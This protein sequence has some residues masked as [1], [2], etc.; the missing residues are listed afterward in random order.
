MSG[1]ISSYFYN[2]KTGFI[3]ADKLYKKLLLDGHNVKLKD[4]K[5]Y[6]EKQYTN[7]INKP[8]K[9]PK[10]FNTIY[11][12]QNRFNYQMDI[13]VYDR[14]TF[15]NY[16]YIL[17]VIDV[18][19]RY[20]SARAMTNRTMPNIIKYTKQIFEEM[21]APKNL[22]LDNEFNKSEFNKLMTQLN[23]YTHYSDPGEINKNAIVER[24][25][26]T[27][28]G[29]IQKWR[30]ATNRYDWNKVL[31]DIVYNYNH[32]KHSTIKA[33]PADVWQRKDINKQKIIKKPAIFKVGDKV[34]LKI[35]KQVFDKGDVITHSK[36]VYIIDRIVGNKYQLKDSNQSIIKLKY[37]DYELSKVEDIQYNDV[38]DADN[39]DDSKK[40][41]QIQ[42]QR[43]ITRSM[44][45]EQMNNFMQPGR[46]E[47]EEERNVRTRPMR[48]AK[49]IVL[50]PSHYNYFFVLSFL[51]SFHL[52]LCLYLLF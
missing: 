45:K 49:L 12:N 40:H 17:M 31:P 10:E 1:N 50:W 30:V 5:K 44:N 16:K 41:D 8:I 4:V 11:A 19:S 9:K 23:I 47:I 20:L 2:P 3:S 18:H 48:N 21:G 46:K 27:I 15:N 43:R 24:A 35:K 26:R 6:L 42:K 32:T 28:A 38:N 7:Q 36:E 34:R 13:M 29:L 37:K 14:Y 22:N 39:V 52:G 51:S 33:T 25:N